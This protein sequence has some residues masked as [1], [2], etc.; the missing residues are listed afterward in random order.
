MSPDRSLPHVGIVVL[1]WKRPYHT[2]A[3]LKSLEGM[4][5]PSWEAVVVDNG[6]GDGSPMLLRR[7]FPEIVVIENGSNLGFAAGS[8]VGIAHVI[9]R[10]A[11]YVLLLND[12]TEVASD[13][14]RLLV[15]TGESA[16]AIGILGP[17]IYYFD[18][19][20]VIWSAGGSVGKYGQAQH[21]GAGQPDDGTLEEVRDVDYVTGCALLTKRKVIERVGLL[22]E[23]FFAY[24]EETEWCARARKA[25]FRVVYVPQARVWHKINLD[26]RA[27]L[28]QYLY[29]MA[30][31]RLLYLKSTHAGP[32]A[33]ALAS[34]DLVRT[35]AT[36][37]LRPRYRHMRPFSGV[38]VRGVRDFALGRLG[39]PPASL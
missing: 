32:L 7:E 23:R 37:S 24:F 38:L 20:N 19:A 15:E 30:R 10:G 36:W 21:L 26:A 11:D 1:N 8:N 33:I 2:I 29:L 34:L 4:D 16:P 3:C 9:G 17:K 35:A 12:D 39:A 28:R 14:V 27:S 5:Y 6:S 31:N 22:D 18:Q 13:A 25:G